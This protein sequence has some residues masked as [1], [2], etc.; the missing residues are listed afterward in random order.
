MLS[1]V[2]VIALTLW[3]E[4]RGESFN[5]RYAVA[6]VI[7]TRSQQTGES[8]RRVCLKPKQ[9]QCW[10][11]GVFQP[12]RPR[13]NEP[14]WIE[15]YTIADAVVKGNVPSSRATHFRDTS[16]HPPWMYAMNRVG[17]IGGL[18]FYAEE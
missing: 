18:I 14:N 17:R 2:L 11:N 1:T 3:G 4:A 8:Y 5:A 7:V 10:K 15:C 16:G 13:G 9:F 6:Q 12:K